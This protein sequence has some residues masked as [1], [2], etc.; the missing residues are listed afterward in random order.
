MKLKYFRVPLY[1]TAFAVF[2]T[3]LFFC[4]NGGK[5]AEEYPITVSAV[6]YVGNCGDNCK[7]T[8]NLKLG[9]LTIEGSGATS[10]LSSKNEIPW[11]KYKNSIEKVVIG[12]GVETVGSF[13]FYGMNRIKSVTLPDSLKSIGE[14]AFCGCESLT[15]VKSSDKCQISSIGDGAFSYCRRIESFPSMPKLKAVG[16]N[17]FYYCYALGSFSLGY[18]VESVGEGAFGFCRELKK[19]RIVNYACDIFESEN[20]FYKDVCIEGFNTSSAKQYADKF[21]RCFEK[22]KDINYLSDLEIKLEYDSIAYSGKKNKPEVKIKGLKNGRDYTVEYT[23]N[24]Q[25]GIAYVKISAAG[26][27]LGE[28]TLSFKI[29]PEK[30]KN[31]RLKSR[32]MNSLSF[33]WDKVH[34]AEKYEVF[35]LKNGK[36]EKLGTVTETSYTAK[37]L[38][39]GT[40]YSF[41]VKAVVGEKENKC[42]GK[43]SAEFVEYTRPQTPEITKLA[44]VRGG[45]KLRV[46]V[47]RVAGVDGYEILMSTKENGKYK[48]VADIKSGKSL[49]ATVDGLS[50]SEK[51]YFKVRSYI[52]GG[53]AVIYSRTGRSVSSNVL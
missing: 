29:T 34:G 28:K 39:A 27:T 31:L 38:A 52:S 7:W 40:K 13:L 24:K 30:V 1:L 47:G 26:N 12:E 50:N 8:L 44:L 53:D 15:A 51:Y 10:D 43:A 35:I 5:K 19:V 25:P 18:S 17:A 48:K 36:W 11:R 45:G 42:T 6:T 41:R 49:T 2:L 16:K 14:N 23:D 37:N 46:T 22:I 9:T 32:K 4:K 3:A 21:S 20:T 33:S